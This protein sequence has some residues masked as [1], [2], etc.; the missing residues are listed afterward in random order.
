MAAQ[1]SGTALGMRSDEGWVGEAENRASGK[2]LRAFRAYLDLLETTAYMRKEMQRPLEAFD[3]TMRTI[4]I[5]EMLYRK[6]RM[7]IG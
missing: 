2:T 4:R 7:A 3:V 1:G 5:L 6:G